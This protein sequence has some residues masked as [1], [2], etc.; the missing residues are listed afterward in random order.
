MA[1][2][3]RREFLRLAAAGL[4]AAAFNQLLAGCTGRDTPMPTQQANQT[5]RPTAVP[6][7]TSTNLPPTET[8]APT[9]THTQEPTQPPTPGIPDLVAAH[10]AEPEVLVRRA[11]T[12][13]GGMEKFVP[14]GANV[15]IKPNICVGYR[16]PEYAVTTNPW[17]VGE[18]VRMCWEAGAGQVRVMDHTYER[19]M[20][21]GYAK[22][23]IKKEVESANG[24]MVEMPEYKFVYTELPLGIDLDSLFLYE[25][26]LNADV[27]INVPIAKHHFLAKLTL[28]M[29][30]L[31]GVMNHR[32][33]MHTNMGQRLADLSSR[34]RPTLNIMDAVKILMANGPTGGYLEDVKQ[35]DTV[36]ASTDIVAL[37]AYTATLFGMQPTELDYVQAAAAMGLGNSDL[38]SLKIEEFNVN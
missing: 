15:I 3:A 17:L 14:K 28:G 13:L 27:L 37:D 5:A 8:P 21:E 25:D 4:T 11:V 12:A 35:L 30:N 36:I 19:Q 23:G 38:S 10:N 34:V 18:L 32:L 7:S 1:K 2:F 33:T 6:S 9:A 22:S 16:S 24:E 20:R 26:V 31:M 29:K